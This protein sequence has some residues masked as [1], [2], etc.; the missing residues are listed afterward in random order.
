MVEPAKVWLKVECVTHERALHDLLI[1]TRP[2]RPHCF[3]HPT[4]LC[5]CSGVLYCYSLAGLR[6]VNLHMALAIC[7]L[8]AA[9]MQTTCSL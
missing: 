7:L 4:T 2:D 1:P 8:V 3:M 5:M 9:S 6:R